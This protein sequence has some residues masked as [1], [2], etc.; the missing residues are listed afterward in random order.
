MSDHERFAIQKRATESDLLRSLITKDWR[1][2]FTFFYEQIAFSLTKN[3]RIARKTDERIHNPGI[4]TELNWYRILVSFWAA[5]KPPK[6]V[7]SPP[8]TH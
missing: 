5:K 6:F 1:E 3:E 7:F 4:D 8:P 2:R